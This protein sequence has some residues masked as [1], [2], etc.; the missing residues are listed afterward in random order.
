VRLTTVALVAVLAILAHAEYEFGVNVLGLPGVQVGP[1]VVSL[2]LAVPA[3]I[4]SYVIA[5]LRAGRDVAYALT[6]TAL[7]VATGTATAIAEPAR[8]VQ[9]VAAALFGAVISVVL[10]RVHELEHAEHRTAD[11]VTALQAEVSAATGHA[12]QAHGQIEALTV[13]LQQARQDAEQARAEAEQARTE[14][15]QQQAETA[16]LTG[17]LRRVQAAPRRAAAAA[18]TTGTTRKTA[19]KA[20]APDAPDIPVEVIET[21]QQIARDLDQAGRN[22]TRAALTEGFRTRGQSLS[23]D[24][25]GALLALLRSTAPAA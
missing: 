7:S 1:V 5:A 20:P 14:V 10:W 9:L 6:L 16:R 4:D 13:D 24:R 15:G 22:L 21:G 18:S 2:A 17:E 3:A 19:T 25:A 12:E 23:N 8:E 11:Q